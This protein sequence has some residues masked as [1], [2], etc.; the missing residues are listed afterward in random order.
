[1]TATMPGRAHRHRQSVAARSPYLIQYA[2][3]RCSV[4]GQPCGLWSARPELTA[5]P[6]HNGI[7]HEPI[8]ADPMRAPAQVSDGIR[9]SARIL[10]AGAQGSTGMPQVPSLRAYF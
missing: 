4:K 9:Q 1:M 7:R 6:D 2:R 5:K 3:C 8:L 10:Q